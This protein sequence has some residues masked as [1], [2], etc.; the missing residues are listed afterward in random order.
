MGKKSK[1]KKEMKETSSKF[2][3]KLIIKISYTSKIEIKMVK[4]F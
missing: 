2:L 3:K 4:I 1:N